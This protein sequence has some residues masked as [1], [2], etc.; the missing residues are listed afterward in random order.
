MCEIDLAYKICEYPV[1]LMQSVLKA[2]LSEN[3]NEN[4]NEINDQILHNNLI[5][6]EQ[7][8][9]IIGSNAIHAHSFADDSIA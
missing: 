5:A 1:L 4:E 7:N 9:S 3:E 8:K 6:F 2:F